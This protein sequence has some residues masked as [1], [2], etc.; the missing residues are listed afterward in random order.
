MSLSTLLLIAPGISVSPTPTTNLLIEY[1]FARRLAEDDAVYA[2]GIR[3][4]P[5]TQNVPGHQIGGLLRVAA[6]W[7]VTKHLTLFMDYEHLAV[8]DVLT[9]AHLPSGSY[10][11]LGAAF[12]WTALPALCVRET[13]TLC[14]EGT[15]SKSTILHHD[16]DVRLY[17]NETMSQPIT[18][19]NLHESTSSTRHRQTAGRSRSR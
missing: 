5:S 10:G 15:M 18:R 14:A 17:Y 6:S 16:L 13:H 1:G 9:R 12:R 8:G 19:A 2:G 7:S 4:Y 3:A 11:H